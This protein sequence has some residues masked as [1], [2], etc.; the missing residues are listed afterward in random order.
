[1][2]TGLP[3]AIGLLGLSLAAAYPAYVH[4]REDTTCPLHSH[5]ARFLSSREAGPLERLDLTDDQKT[6]IASV[7]AA[8]RDT[9][10]PR[11]DA[12][13][14]ARIRQVEVAHAEPLDEAALR[15]ACREAAA[16]EEELV[17]G[18][19]RVVEQLRPLLTEKQRTMIK[20]ARPEVF[21]GIEA[22]LPI[23]R[24]KVSLW[25]DANS[26]Q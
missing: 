18:A 13:L 9:M 26:G 15:Q 25:I 19:V 11:I 8:N 4:A 5:I 2:K 1:M 12:W 14:A 16:V 7:L 17:V 20:L 23:L 6:K 21:K 22:H 10:H 24:E 3:I